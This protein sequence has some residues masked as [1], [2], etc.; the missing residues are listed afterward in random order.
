MATMNP[1]P[2]GAAGP[3]ARM[4]AHPGWP[5]TL[6]ATLDAFLAGLRQLAAA[7]VPGP[8]R[9]E[10]PARLFGWPLLAVDLGP[11]DPGAE[12]RHA[13]GIVAIGNRATGALALGAYLARGGLAV[14]VRAAGLVAIGVA[15]A[16]VLSVGVVGL[17]LVSVATVSTGYLAVGIVAVG[18]ECVGVVA[19]GGHAVGILGA[20]QTARTLFPL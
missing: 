12:P 9:Y 16:G 6:A 2:A 10:S 11:D 5:G 20:G 18:Y 13:R 4:A 7:L 1:L 3:L 8:Y 17:G 15:G 14:G 19:V